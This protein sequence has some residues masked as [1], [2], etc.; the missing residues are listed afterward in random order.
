MGSFGD[1]YPESWSPTSFPNTLNE[2]KM[3]WPGL[4]GSYVLYFPLTVANTW[5]SPSGKLA[6]N[7]KE[8][9]EDRPVLLRSEPTW[10]MEERLKEKTPETSNYLMKR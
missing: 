10:Q 4:S 9:A 6:S 7:L 3:W 1:T 5:K 2:F 8:R